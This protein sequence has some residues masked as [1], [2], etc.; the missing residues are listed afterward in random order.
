MDKDYTL[1]YAAFYAD[2]ESYEFTDE[3]ERFLNALELERYEQKVPMTPAEKRALRKWVAAGNSVSENPG[4]R[5]ICSQGCEPPMDF[6]AVYRFDRE[7]DTI[8]K[9]KS[10]LEK[11]HY[12]KEYFGYESPEEKL[13]KT[14][15]QFRKLQRESYYLW[16]FISAHGLWEEAREFLEDNMDEPML[17]EPDW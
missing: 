10:K 3:D 9:G 5:Y 7:L 4:S 12:L 2:P 16:M 6:L 17:L 14:E 13:Q 8:L 11:D 15:E 1:D